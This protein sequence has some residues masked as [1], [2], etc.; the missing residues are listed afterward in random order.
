MNKLS[1][2]Y[3]VD[4]YVPCSKF[5][6]AMSIEVDHY[7]KSPGTYISDN[8]SMLHEGFISMEAVIFLTL[9]LPVRRFIFNSLRNSIFI[10]DCV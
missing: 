3:F 6:L 5:S 8:P 1:D 7:F 2:K 9:I 4:I 10:L